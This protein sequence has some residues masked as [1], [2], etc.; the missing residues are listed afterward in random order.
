MS[1]TQ[2]IKSALAQIRSDVNVDIVEAILDED[3]HLTVRF[4]AITGEEPRRT[5]SFRV[6]DPESYEEL[7]ETILAK[8]KLLEE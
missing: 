8:R 1:P 5:K 2:A 3:G 7:V 6:T 4:E